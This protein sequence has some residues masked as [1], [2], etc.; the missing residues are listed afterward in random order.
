MISSLSHSSKKFAV[1]LL[2]NELL[3]KEL[4]EIEIKNYGD[5]GIKYIT[6]KMNSEIIED[7]LFWKKY[8]QIK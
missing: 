5:Y 3:I 2:N 4:P 7:T 8:S 1:Q 6:E